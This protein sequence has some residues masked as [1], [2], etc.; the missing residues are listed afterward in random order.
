M[1][2]QKTKFWIYKDDEEPKEEKYAPDGGY[3][4]RILFVNKS[5]EVQTEFFNEGGNEKFKYFYMDAE[6]G[7]SE[8]DLK[9]KRVGFKKKKN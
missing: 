1:D 8:F 3:I 2:I 6:S 7:K 9:R 5:G 4:P